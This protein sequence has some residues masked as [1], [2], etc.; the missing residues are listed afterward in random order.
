VRLQLELSESAA[1]ILRP[2]PPRPKSHPSY[3]RRLLPAF[4]KV[5]KMHDRSD[6]ALGLAIIARN[7]NIM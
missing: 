2:A 4:L 3:P 1:L 5:T 7:A 6:I